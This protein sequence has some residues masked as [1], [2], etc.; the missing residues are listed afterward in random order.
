MDKGYTSVASHLREKRSE[1]LIAALEDVVTQSN[2][3]NLNASRETISE[4][5]LWKP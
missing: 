3:R 5:I 1:K 4:A 2:S